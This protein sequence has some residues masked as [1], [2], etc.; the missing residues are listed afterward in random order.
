MR[1]VGAVRRTADMAEE[2]V[3]DVLNLVV[4]EGDPIAVV[5]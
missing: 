1:V 5:G 4:Q 3:T 2:I